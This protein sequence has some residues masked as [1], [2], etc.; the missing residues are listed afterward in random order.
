V[1]A[2]TEERSGGPKGGLTAM[3]LVITASWLLILGETYVLFDII[4]PL[5][6]P[7]H[8]ANVPSAILKVGLTAGLGV[9]WV[10]VMFGIWRLYL[11][12]HRTPT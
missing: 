7:L 5:G 3:L 8:E 9:L 12:A 10:V 11:R 6:P 1:V 4:R 2:V